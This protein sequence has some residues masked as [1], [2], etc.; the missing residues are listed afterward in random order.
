MTFNINWIKTL[1]LMGNL[2]NFNVCQTL[3]LKLMEDTI[4][5]LQLMVRQQTDVDQNTIQLKLSNK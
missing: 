4:Q 5:T 1:R 3:D 2:R